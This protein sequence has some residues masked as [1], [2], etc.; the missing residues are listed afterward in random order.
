MNDRFPLALPE[1]TVLAGQYVIEK[2]LGQGGFGITYKAVD[3][4][5]GKYVAV[6]EFFPDSMATRSATMVIPFTGERGDSFNYGKDCFLKEAETLA[7]F[8][9]NENIV[10]IFTYFEENSTAYFVMEYIEGKSFDVYIRERGGR[11][12]FDEAAAVL[13]PVMDALNDVHSKGIVHRDVTPDNIYITNDGVVKLLDFGAARYSLGDK[14]RS[15]DVVLKH[16]FAPKEQYTRRG[17]QGPFT[18]VYSLGAS[19]YYAITGK[20][21][22]DSVERMDNDELIPPSSLGADIGRVPEQA[23][24]NALNVQPGDRFQSMAA[25]KNAMLGAKAIDAQE[26]AAYGT[27]YY[28]T[29]ISGTELYN[30]GAYG[31]Q[32]PGTNYQQS[33]AQYAQ[34]T[35]NSQYGSQGYGTNYQQSGAQYAQGTGNSQYGSQ[36]YGTNY[37]QS[38]RTAPVGN[39][40]SG[41]NSGS[42]KKKN[43]IPII[44]IASAVAVLLLVIGTIA[45]V[46][47]GSKKTEATTVATGTTEN[48][49]DEMTTAEPVTTHRDTVDISTPS[50]E[51]TTEGTTESTTE[52]PNNG[53]LFPDILGNTPGNLSNLG[54]VALDSSGAEYDADY[55]GKRLIKYVKDGADEVLYEGAYIWNLSIVD[56]TLYFIANRKAYTMSL[57]GTNLEEIRELSQYDDIET[58]FVSEDYYFALRVDMGN[59]ISRIISVQ[60]RSGTLLGEIRLD[61]EFDQEAHIGS[62]QVTFSNGKMYYLLT[63]NDG[64]NY[65][66]D[67]GEHLWCLPAG[68][69]SATPEA[70][71]DFNGYCGEI[72]AD[73]NY[74]YCLTGD[75]DLK[76]LLYG[77][78]MAKLS[79]YS[80]VADFNWDK[81]QFQFNYI[82]VRDD[83]LSVI[84]QGDGGTSIMSVKPVP[85]A[86]SWTL[87]YVKTIETDTFIF[88]LNDMNNGYYFIENDKGIFFMGHDGNGYS[89]ISE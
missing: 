24:L 57:D 64:K 61:Y 10:R 6:K 29:Q 28:N 37:Q 82:N 73:D 12:S 68:N 42:G 48:I 81:E 52:A 75:A 32:N 54:L 22:P 60:R 2:V 79:D 3:H 84:S 15:L 88:G 55:V 14:S 46:K 35:G 69:L 65:S 9:G 13:I 4:N 33:G 72:V 63:S 16:G 44:I 51:A 50:T 47:S 77:I 19:F 20:R 66:A 67:A 40:G 17:K 41:S 89:N 26:K 53:D 25:F 62:R 27:G 85:N 30:G 1:G 34:G 83:R 71:L 76:G 39:Y 56:D 45:I 70:C 59:D 31:S 11:V 43:I 5:T 36:G 49:T 86:E 38:N 7:R 78:A 8:I 23:I 74:I 58:L 87:N 21:P 18:D 80:V